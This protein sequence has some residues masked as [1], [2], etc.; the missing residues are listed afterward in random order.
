MPDPVDINRLHRAAGAASRFAVGRGRSAGLASPP[1]GGEH[2]PRRVLIVH[3]FGR[4]IAPYAT[5]VAVFRRELALRSPEPV[6]FIET[7]LDAGR[8]IGPAE[9]AAFAAYLR[10]RF[11]DPAPELIVS[12]AGPAAQFL[13]RWRDTIFPGV[14]LMSTAVDERIVPRARRRP[15]DALVAA[16]IDLPWSFDALMRL[17]P[18]TTTIA[19][20]LGT[21]PLEQYW[22]RQMEQD[23][24]FLA[25][26]VRFV[27]LDGLS[28]P[29]IAQRVATL[30]PHSAVYF[31]L[32]V[33]DGA[34]VP[35]EGLQALSEL[36]Q[37]ANAPIF[38]IFESELGAGVVGG[39]YIS[40]TLLGSE[41]ARLALQQLALG[42][43]A[44]VQDVAVGMDT[45]AYDQREL[46]RWR[47][48]ESRL[49]PGGERRFQPLSPW[50][51]YRTAI[52]ATTGVL[53][54]QT[55]LIAAL[56]LQR[57]RRQRAER[58]A[59]SLGGRLISAYEDESRR[60]GRELHD[61]VTQR[62]AGL[63]METAALGRLE[64][65]A[66]RHAAEQG[67]GSELA[68][69]SRDVNALAYRLH[70]SV[71]EDLGLEEA[72]RVECERASRRGAL[73]VVFE[74][75]P[76]ADAVRA[77][78]AEPVSRGAGSAAQCAAPRAGPAHRR[79][80]AH[81]WRRRRAARG[82]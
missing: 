16:R 66:V 9:Q 76:G 52:L 19:V 36:R 77:A 57:A 56:L 51:Q 78:G 50:V 61:D 27:W 3:S 23:T 79:R 33:V 64:D 49:L 34:G 30:P 17:L 69:L 2:L 20:V 59:R 44:G 68:R 26:R 46:R 71:L 39:P 28:L 5:T 11:A 40:Q 42:P 73:P 10:E 38:S 8:T 29:Q 75:S 65:P 55:G 14:P 13:E 1:S 53:L 67:I 81:R 22:R 48:D 43:G 6:V 60:L 80:A 41:T 70:P 63:S 74:S 54:A 35:Y 21:T 4:E 7:A 58:E 24:T 32:L 15:G 25:G 45:V 12:V 72:L 37:A 82:R 47:I 18:D 31:G 62:L